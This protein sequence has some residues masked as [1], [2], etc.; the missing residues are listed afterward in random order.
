[1]AETD[2][3]VPQAVNPE[4]TA[5]LTRLLQIRG[6][7][8]ILNVLD[9]IVPVVSL[10]NVVTPDINIRGPIFRSTDVFSAGAQAAPAT[11]A[12]LADTLALPDGT[13]DVKIA[14]NIN[15]SANRQLSVEHRNAANTANLMVFD[16]P[17]GLD[18]SMMGMDKL[19]F[20]Y[21]LAVNER[22]RVINS[23][24]AGTVGSGYSV[25]IF[26]RIR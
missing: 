18:R 8:G 12:V 24:T 22:L 13:Y 5:N 20:S 6:P 16:I 15:E 21:V 26:A 19:S 2:S 3:R 11:G 25:V 10:G 1:M 17:M 14:I 7:L 9:T 23:G 4:V